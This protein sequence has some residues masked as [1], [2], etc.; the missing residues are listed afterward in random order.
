METLVSLLKSFAPALATAVSGPLGGA[1]VSMIAER[2]GVSGTVQSVV[3]ALQTDP[4][5]TQKLQELE[6]EFAKLNAA[7]RD[8]ARRREVEVARTDAPWLVKLISPILALLV[9]STAFSLIGV[10]MFRDLPENQEQILIFALGFIT[11]AATQVLSYYFGSSQGSKD[12]NDVLAGI[13]R[14]G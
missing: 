1:A 7:D 14:H 8:S 9:V 6:L 2:L 12:K 10:M 13:K 11:S 5:A 4:Q 3:D